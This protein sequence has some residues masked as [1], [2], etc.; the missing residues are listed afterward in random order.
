MFLLQNGMTVPVSGACSELGLRS[1][2]GRE[3][4]IGFRGRINVFCLSVQ[5][6]WVS[7][8]LSLSCSYGILKFC[9]DSKF[10]KLRCGDN[11]CRFS[12]THG[13]SVSHY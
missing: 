2:W 10:T 3:K 7:H 9:E 12:D 6:F 1:W 8:L 5:L 13:F 11:T 4:S